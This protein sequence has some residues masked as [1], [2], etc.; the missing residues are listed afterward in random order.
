LRPIFKVVGCHPYLLLLHDVLLMKVRLAAIDED[1]G[2][3]L[4]VVPEK[5]HL[6]KPL[7]PIVVMF[8]GSRAR[9]VGG[10]GLPL[11]SQGLDHRRIGL[12]GGLQRLHAGRKCLQGGLEVV[13][14]GVGG[15]L[16]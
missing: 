1:E 9:S 14:H 15:G 3:G 8:A 10:R 16:W 12:D 6:L 13:T 4:A 2:V 11:G 5:I 7:R